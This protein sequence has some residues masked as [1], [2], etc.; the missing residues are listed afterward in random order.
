MFLLVLLLSQ[1]RGKYERISERGREG[2]TVV[3][4]V[5]AALIERWKVRSCL[6]FAVQSWP[7]LIATNL[8]QTF[9]FP[10]EDDYCDPTVTRVT[11]IILSFIC[12]LQQ[13][14]FIQARRCSPQCPGPRPHSA[15]RRPRRRCWRCCSRR[16]PQA[17]PSRGN[18]S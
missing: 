2:R 13:N 15:C 9:L 4:V 11:Y 3:V 16:C 5:A 12:W 17:P 18:G 14:I 6:D 7:G 8:T 1:P 10:S